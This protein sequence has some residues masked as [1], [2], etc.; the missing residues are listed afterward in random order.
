MMDVHRAIGKMMYRVYFN[1]YADNWDE[2]FALTESPFRR[3][4]VNEVVGKTIY[5]YVK[6]CGMDLGGTPY[7]LIPKRI[8][9]FLRKNSAIIEVFFL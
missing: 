7:N 2:C 9:R 8:E 3:A 1:T 5:E 4:M 6:L